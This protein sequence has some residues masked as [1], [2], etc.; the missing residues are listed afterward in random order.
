MKYQSEHTLN[1]ASIGL[2]FTPCDWEKADQTNWSLVLPDPSSLTRL[3]C[4]SILASRDELGEDQRELL[5]K[6]GNIE[7]WRE[8]VLNS[9]RTHWDAFSPVLNYYSDIPHRGQ[10]DTACAMQSRLR[11]TPI[12]VVKIDN[13]YKLSACADYPNMALEFCRAYWL[14]GYLPPFAMIDLSQPHGPVE[15]ELIRACQRTIELVQRQCTT[16]AS[17]LDSSRIIATAC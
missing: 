12:V 17:A 14:L 16:L 3:Q 6:T 10:K 7:L 8:A 2:T 5:D 9:D 1:G 15:P 11:H 4:I 13:T